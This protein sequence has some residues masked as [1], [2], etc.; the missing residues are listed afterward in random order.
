MASTD[1]ESAPTESILPPE[2]GVQ[3]WICVV[4]GFLGLFGTF[5]FLN[6]VGVFQS[7]Y[8]ETSLKNYNSSEVSWI[9]AVQIC[10]MWAGGPLWG[11]IIDTYGAAPV[12]YPCSLLCVFSLCMTSLADEYYQI[13]LAQGLGFGIGA[14]GVFTTSMVCVG[15][16]FVK[17]RG[18]AVGIA[19]CGSS[20][21]GV[22]FPIFLNKVIEDVGFYGAVRYTALFVGVLL[23][24]ACL[25]VRARVPRKTWNRKTPWFDV[26]LFKQKQFALLTVGTYLVMFVTTGLDAADKVYGSAASIPGRIIPPYLADHIGHFN[27]L[28]TCSL[29][30][31]GSML[32][33]WLPFNFHPSHA[34]I[35]VFALVYGFVSGAV[36]SLVMPCVAKSGSIET[37]GQ[38]FGTF[39]LVISVS[40][41]TGLP[42]MG[43]ILSRQGGTDFS[44][45]QIFAAVASLLGAG[46]LVC[47]T[48]LL[49]QS[50]GN[51]RV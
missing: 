48:H 9:F 16:W 40:C 14:G 49:S 2:E 51:W 10:L 13:F 20:F 12:L 24:S 43:G 11:R 47:S 21:G 6:A 4:G 25:M 19:S 7:I 34:G 5:G 26:T 3:G 46:F 37:L 42:L 27:V 44:G 39:Q 1:K 29:M 45:L 17:R 31:G 50:R 15:Q 35:I 23:A 38:R 22:I 36:V 8:E 33:L 32:V 41:L 18:L 30:T 28:T